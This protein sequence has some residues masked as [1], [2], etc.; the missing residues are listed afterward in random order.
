MENIKKVVDKLLS[1]DYGNYFELVNKAEELLSERGLNIKYN[2]HYE[3]ES[4]YLK[5]D[6]FFAMR[7]LT[8]EQLVCLFDGKKF[9]I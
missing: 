3:F 6:I 8:E 2:G 7:C 9:P 1:Q 5:S 4:G